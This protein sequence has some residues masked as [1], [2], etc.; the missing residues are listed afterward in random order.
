LVLIQHEFGLFK[1]N[2]ADF[3]L[4][5]AINKPI[6]IVFH[7]VLP[8]PDTTE[9]NIAEMN[10]IV[11]SFIVMTH[12]SAKLLEQDYGILKN[13]ITVIP[14]GTHLVKYIDKEALKEKYKL[15]GKKIISTFGLLSSGKSIETSLDAMPVMIAKNR[16]SVSDY[17][18]NTPICC[19][20][21]R[22][23]RQSLEQKNRNIRTSASCKIH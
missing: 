6:I 23:N 19:T 3:I 12:A 21:R 7:T 1:T 8:N 2:E 14:H 5:K 13:K 9:K 20:R 17:R 22:R 10:A 11:D 15:S 18:Q 16:Y 4:L